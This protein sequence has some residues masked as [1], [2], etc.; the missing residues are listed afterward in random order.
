LHTI[1]TADSSVLSL[2]LCLS[3]NIFLSLYRGNKRELLRQTLAKKKKFLQA[4]TKRVANDAKFYSLYFPQWQ[5]VEQIIVL[6]IGAL[7]KCRKLC[8]HFGFF[9]IKYQYFLLL[10]SFLVYSFKTVV[11]LQATEE[12]KL[13]F[14]FLKALKS[15]SGSNKNCKVLITLKL[16]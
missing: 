13:I 16:N 14:T 3:K 15:L 11:V 7:K 8:S 2:C 6:V 1:V 12:N 10:N 5:W 4:A 9:R